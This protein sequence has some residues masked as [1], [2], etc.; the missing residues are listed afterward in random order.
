MTS[1]ILEHEELSW[2]TRARRLYRKF[3]RNW[4]F[5][6]LLFTNEKHRFFSVNCFCIIYSRHSL[7]W[8]IQQR[9]Y[10]VFN[11]DCPQIKQQH[12]K[13]QVHEEVRRLI[14]EQSLNKEILDCA[15]ATRKFL[16]IRWCKKTIVVMVTDATCQKSHVLLRSLRP[17]RLL[18]KTFFPVSNMLSNTHSLSLSRPSRLR[19]M[20]DA[21]RLL[22]RLS[23]THPAFNRLRC[24]LRLLRGK[25]KIGSCVPVLRRVKSDVFVFLLI[26]YQYL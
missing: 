18:L 22:W 2:L 21:Q 8:I 7:N 11:S 25:H 13:I 16:N 14:S 26:M 5:S 9:K 23:E 6:S 12:V 20:T 4:T 1:D 10:N 3:T 15:V 19:T 24:T 17:A